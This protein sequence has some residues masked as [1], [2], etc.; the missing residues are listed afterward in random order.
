MLLQGLKLAENTN[1]AQ[2]ANCF[3]VVFSELPHDSSWVR[4]ISV[5]SGVMLDQDVED[6]LQQTVPMK[7][8]VYAERIESVTIM[9]GARDL[10]NQ[11]LQ[12][13]EF[14]QPVLTTHDFTKLRWEKRYIY[15]Q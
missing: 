7:N 13:E 2:I 9:E 4:I 14:R 15:L 8:V 3:G 5:I 12:Q 11:Q 10:S 6:Y 1:L